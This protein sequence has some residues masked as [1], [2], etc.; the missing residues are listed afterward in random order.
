MTD[1]TGL[2]RERGVGLEVGVVGEEDV[3]RQWTVSGGVHLDVQVRGS[4]RV[5]AE[6]LQ[7]FAARAVRGY[8]VAAWP[9]G[10]EPVGALSISGQEPPEI[11][12]FLQRILRIVEP[13]VVG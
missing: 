2:D 10:P 1:E 6:R 3:R 7:E 12:L 5:A 9:H 8:R 11:S 13:H 4:H